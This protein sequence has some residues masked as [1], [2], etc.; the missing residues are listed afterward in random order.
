MTVFVVPATVGGLV[1]KLNRFPKITEELESKARASLPNAEDT[2]DR[3]HSSI[4]LHLSIG[5][6][7]IAI[8][9]TFAAE[10]TV[11]A[12]RKCRAIHVHIFNCSLCAL[13]VARLVARVRL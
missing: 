12:A 5:G 2:R 13:F 1:F 6:P 9:H 8:R 7:S 3:I 10:K 4:E 11:T